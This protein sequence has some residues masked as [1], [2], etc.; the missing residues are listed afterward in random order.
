VVEFAIEYQAN[1]GLRK[2]ALARRVT[3]DSTFAWPAPAKA[4][5]EATATTL[6]SVLRKS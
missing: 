6:A 4:G 1:Q 2:I 5:G 3:E